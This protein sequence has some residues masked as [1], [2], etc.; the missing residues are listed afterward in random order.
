MP[1]LF[2]AIR[3]SRI[4]RIKQ[5]ES[6]TAHARG[7]DEK[8]KTRRVK[9]GPRAIA[10][11]LASG[12]N[13]ARVVEVGEETSDT[14]LVA[15]FR[16]HKKDHGAGERPNSAFALHLLAIVSP[17][18]LEEIPKSK[19]QRREALTAEAVKWANKAFGPPDSV[20][21]AR[22]DV[23][24]AG[25]GVVDLFV[26]PIREQKLGGRGAKR[27]A[28]RCAPTQA[29]KEIC[30]KHG[31]TR[32]YSALQDSWAEYVQATLDPRIQRGKLKTPDRDH[33]TPEAY[34]AKVREA[35]ALEDSER[36][37][38]RAQAEK[39]N[40]AKARAEAEEADREADS[41]RE[42][43]LRAKTAEQQ[44]RQDQ[45]AAEADAAQARREAA[46][47][48]Q[49]AREAKEVAEKAGEII[50]GLTDQLV[51]LRIENDH[52][53]QA[54]G[55]LAQKNRG[56]AAARK[57]LGIECEKLKSNYNTLKPRAEGW[58]AVW[59]AAHD[60][61]AMLARNLVRPVW[62]LIQKTL[63]P[64]VQKAAR[65]HGIDLD[66]DPTEHGGVGL[67]DRQSRKV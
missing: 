37:K 27:T 36:A 33:L 14:D 43:A 12:K 60:E 67:P 25:Q 61:G 50:P 44:A 42:Q 19:R 55:K 56:L 18:W 62:A 10:W 24:E 38:A 23:D 9:D 59:D 13:T 26:A 35:Q 15:A 47:A 30:A 20:F 58:A 2:A 1:D 7:M 21:A 46:E 4:S 6:M 34:R 31:Q 29:L 39:R 65:F 22:Y 48:K 63:I 53:T 54:N 8:C 49:T 3:C 28:L 66:R 16:Q 40:A 45:A 32:T 5:L 51:G 64:L 41:H 11:S 17:E 57:K 52:L